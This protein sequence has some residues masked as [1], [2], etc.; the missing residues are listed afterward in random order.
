[1]EKSIVR[2]D[3]RSSSYRKY[4][5]FSLESKAMNFIVADPFDYFRVWDSLTCARHFRVAEI[6][7][8]TDDGIFMPTRY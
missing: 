7:K 4:Y 5:G 8:E 1:L 2:R 6:Q 3:E